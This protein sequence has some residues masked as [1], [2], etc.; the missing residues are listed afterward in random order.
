MA[1]ILVLGA[2][3]LGTAVLTSLS[4]LSP[5]NTKISVLLRPSSISHPSPSKARELNALLALSNP[6][7][8][9]SIDLLP[10]D[11]APSFISSLAAVFQPYDLVVSCLGFGEGLPAG[12][13]MKIARAA[14]DAKVKRFVPWQF[15][16]DY[17][18]IGKG[19]GQDLFDEQLDVRS[20]LKEQEGEGGTEWVIISVGM[21]M[22]FLFE[23]FWGVVEFPASSGSAVNKGL[24][25]AESVEGYEVVV[26]ALG[27][28]ENRITVTTAEDIGKL[29]AKILFG[30]GTNY[31]KNMVV[32][33]ASETFSYGDLAAVVGEVTG[34]KVKREV[35]SVEHL[36]EELRTDP[37]NGL[38]KYRVV[39]AEGR[40]CWWDLE[41]AWNFKN[42][43]ETVGVKDFMLEKGMGKF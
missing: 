40:G 24:T 20:L 21:F 35:W 12:T 28:W 39:F 22:S 23:P 17:E 8:G 30:T 4:H 1:N 19:S 31:V 6:D 33:I 18:A 34:R 32:H 29:T 15:G 27:S 16:V 2:G 42:G 36:K 43:V 37:E 41:R 9:I 26:R 13:S 7:K 11:L 10:F 5:P 25:R 38:K 14:I 3:E